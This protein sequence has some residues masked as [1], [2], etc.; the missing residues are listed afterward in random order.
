M[1]ITF[2]TEFLKNHPK[3][4]SKTLFVPKLW[5]AWKEMGIEINDY[6]HPSLDEESEYLKDEYDDIHPKW[7]TIR[8]GARWRQGA[9]FDPRIWTDGFMSKQVPL[10]LEPVKVVKELPITI[11][12]KEVH[13]SDQL[14]SHANLVYLARNDGFDNI[15]DFFAWFN[16][17]RFRGQIIFWKY[18]NYV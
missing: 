2:A 8:K 5:K 17:G 1:V 3:S 7:H 11:D 4:G 6:G 9:H 14:V 12:N 15:E 18:I 10:T 16:T 13:I